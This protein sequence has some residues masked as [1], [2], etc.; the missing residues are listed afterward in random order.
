[1]AQAF[2][3]GLTVRSGV[4]MRK[5]R[6]LPLAGETLVQVGDRVTASQEVARAF[7]PGD[8][9]IMRLPEKMGLEPFEVLKGLRVKEGDAVESGALLCEHAGFFGWLKTRFVSTATG[10]VEF[11]SERTGHVGVRTASKPVTL[12]A[13]ISGEVVAVE[14]GKSVL[15]ETSGALVQGIFGVGGERSGV[16]SLL[17]VTEDQ[18]V[19]VSDL[20]ANCAGLILVGGASAAAS[21]LKEAAARGALGF[22]VGSVDD[23]ALKS[24]VGHEIGIALTGDEKVAMTLIITEGFG[25]LAMSKRIVQLLKAF[26]GRRVSINGATQ[27]RAGALRPELIVP[28]VSAENTMGARTDLEAAGLQVGSHVRLIR[29]PYFGLRGEVVELPHAMEEIPTGAHARVL[30]A[31][32]ADGLVVTVPR[33][34]VELCS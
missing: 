13:Y 23:K 12:A 10:I 26:E 29:V 30:R 24:Y 7:L 21:V 8:L 2:T 15:I 28:D 14:A 16:L 18:A 25:K 22:M 33:A 17:P 9:H 5:L 32:L 6:E 3:P 1:M 19:E 4:V 27:V 31:K 20:P 11:I 34:N